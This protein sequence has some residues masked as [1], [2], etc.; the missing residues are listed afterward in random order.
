MYA[1]LSN[2][3]L[4]FSPAFDFIKGTQPVLL[5][6][7]SLQ[8]ECAQ[9]LTLVCVAVLV[10]FHSDIMHH[11]V[12]VLSSITRSTFAGYLDCFLFRDIT[13]LCLYPGVHVL[14]GL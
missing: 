10:H 3:V 5:C 2:N 13:F 1:F 4:L 11:C 6:L 7:L 9:F 8:A 14:E 12:G